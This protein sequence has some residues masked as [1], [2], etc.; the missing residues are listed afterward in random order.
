MCTRKLDIQ[1]CTCSNNINKNIID[2]YK[3]EIKFS[4]KSNTVFPLIK[5][6]LKELA[7][8]KFNGIEGMI[9]LPENQFLNNLKANFFLNQINNKNCFDFK[10][11][12]KKGDNLVLDLYA[13][14]KKG[15]IKKQQHYTYMS[16]IYSDLFWEIDYYDPFTSTTNIAINGFVKLSSKSL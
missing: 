11:S 8:D 4:K 13:I 16:F 12:P 7:T 5:W 3:D 6:S 2:F 15:K 9:I 14:I 10:Y 1:F